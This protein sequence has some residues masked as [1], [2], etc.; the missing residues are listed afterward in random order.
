MGMLTGWS[1]IV[2]L[3][4]WLDFKDK[5]RHYYDHFWYALAILTCL[6]LLPIRIGLRLLKSS[7]GGINWRV[8]RVPTYCNK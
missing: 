3:S 8:K 6:F 7:S 5:F 1:V 2:I 4:D